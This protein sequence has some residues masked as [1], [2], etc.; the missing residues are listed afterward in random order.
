MDLGMRAGGVEGRAEN[1][2]EQVRPSSENMEQ[3]CVSNLLSKQDILKYPQ[4]YSDHKSKIDLT[5]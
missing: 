2:Q 1:Q 4:I 5:Y 3:S